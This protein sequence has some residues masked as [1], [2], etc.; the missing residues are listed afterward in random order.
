MKY[1]SNVTNLLLLK[2]LDSENSNYKYY[3]NKFQPAIQTSEDPACTRRI[4][5][6][7]NYLV[8]SVFL[9]SIASYCLSLL[10]AWEYP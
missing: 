7:G 10:H 2:S 6:L 3:N 5:G 1:F 4:L 8:L 9:H